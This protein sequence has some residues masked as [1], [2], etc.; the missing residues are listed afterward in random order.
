MAFT[1][2]LEDWFCS[3]FSSLSDWDSHEIR[4]ERATYQLLELLEKR[5]AKATFFILG[6]IAEKRQQLVKDIS[7]HGHEIASHGYAHRLV[8]TLTPSEFRNDIRRSKEILEQLTGSQIFGYR[9]PC[10]SITEWGLEILREEGYTYDASVGRGHPHSVDPSSDLLSDKAYQWSN[11]LWELPMPYYRFG[12]LT[13][14]CGGGGYFRLY[15][16]SIYK[17]MI[18]ENLRKR[19]SFIYYIHPADLD[20]EQPRLLHYSYQDSFKRYY[21]LNRTYGKIKRLLRD[22]RWSSIQDCY[23]QAMRCGY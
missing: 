9:A 18:Q 12:P 23:P 7:R 8:Y 1:V 15:P 14:P 6:W 3:P 10:F 22:F 19:D 4:V 16:Y 13:L 5:S 11:G 20:P 17:R 21:G 2:D